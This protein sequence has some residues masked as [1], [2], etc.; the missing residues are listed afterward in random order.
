MSTE[1]SHH[2]Y[3]DK[4]KHGT[5]QALLLMCERLFHSTDLPG[6]VLSDLIP[7]EARES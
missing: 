6:S 2:V 5:S 4:I 7:S 1:N 3:A